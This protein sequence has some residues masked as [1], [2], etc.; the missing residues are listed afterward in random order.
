MTWDDALERLVKNGVYITRI[1]WRTHCDEVGHYVRKATRDEPG[2]FTFVYWDTIP[3]RPPA[4]FTPEQ[5]DFDAAD[6]HLLM[7]KFVERMEP[8][9]DAY[10]AAVDAIS[11]EI[12][13]GLI[14]RDQA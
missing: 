8:V 5:D 4:M 1:A 9:Y 2:L 10:R 3:K 6:W 11:N 12:G 7:P 14:R 13:C